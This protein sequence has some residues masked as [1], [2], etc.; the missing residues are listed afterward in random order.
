MG[1]LSD[2]FFVEEFVPPEL[3]GKFADNSRWFIDPAAVKIAE[4][5]RARFGKAVIINDW[6]SGLSNRGFRMPDTQTGGFLSQHKFGRAFDSNI[7][8]MAPQEVYD[9]IVNNFIFW[10]NSGLTAVE[11]ISFTPTWVHC[12]CRWTGKTELM[13]VKP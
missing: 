3:Y 2:H 6:K 13:I 12:D 8:G 11:D 7:S 5:M 10:R 1:K 9:D 4:F